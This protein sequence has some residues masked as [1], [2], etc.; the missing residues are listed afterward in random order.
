MAKFSVRR[1]AIDSF[2]EFADGTLPF[3][4]V[5]VVNEAEVKSFDAGQSFERGE[6]VFEYKTK[7]LVN[8][9][10][11]SR[12]GVVGVRF[13]IFTR[14]PRTNNLSSDDAIETFEVRFDTAQDVVFN[15]GGQNLFNAFNVTAPP[16]SLKKLLVANTS[17]MTLP[18]V[19]S[20]P[21]LSNILPGKTFKQISK[22][23]KSNNEDPAQVSAAGNFSA[24]TPFSAI[25]LGS[26]NNFFSHDNSI[27]SAA[28]ARAPRTRKSLASLRRTNRSA[29]RGKQ[30]RPLVRA[31]VS[32]SESRSRRSSVSFA[33]LLP[34]KREYV[35]T[36][37]L[38]KGEVQGSEKLYASISSIGAPRSRCIFTKTIVEI[39]H[40][41]EL[42]ELLANPE[43]PDV[44]LIDAKMASVSIVLKRTDPTL[45]VVR[46]FRI[47][48]NSNVG[49][50]YVDD[51]T[52]LSFSESPESNIVIFEDLLDN[53]LPNKTIYRFAVVN[54]DGSIGEFSSIVIPSFKNVSDPL[55]TA[56]IP[57][58]IRAINKNAGVDIRV[59][60]LSDDIFTIRLLRQ[61]FHKSG[62]FDESVEE[63][64]SIEGDLTVF[65]NGQKDAFYFRD[66]T[67]VLG[68]HYRYFVAYRTGT[69]GLASLGEEIISDE[70]ET[71]IR[72]F[73]TGEIPF[74]I[75]LT[76]PTALQDGDN[77]TTVTFE[78]FSEPTVDFFKT[79][80]TALRDAG[81]DTQFISNLSKDDLKPKFFTMFLVERINLNTGRRVSFGITP[82]GKFIDDSDK[83][84]KLG[85]PP[86]VSNGRYEYVVKTCLQQPEVFLQASTVGLINRY[87]DEIQ[88]LASRFAR[89]IYSRM[90]VLPPEFDVR[91]GRSIESL[92][93]ESQVGQELAV[94]VAIPK[95]EPIIE[96]MT[97]TE[98]SLYSSLTWRVSGDVSNVSYFLI[99]C[100][101]D[102][103]DQLLGAI[104]CSRGSALYRYRDDRFYGETGE[105]SYSVRAV[106]F[107]DD[108]VVKSPSIN[109][110]KL[111]SVPE[112]LLE[113]V[114]FSYGKGKNY[115]Q[116]IG[117]SINFQNPL[118]PPMTSPGVS[119]KVWSAQPSQLLEAKPKMPD[120][121]A[122]IFSWDRVDLPSFSG[123]GG[124]NKISQLESTSIEPSA[125][126]KKGLHSGKIDPTTV[127]V[128]DGKITS[129]IGIDKASLLS[130]WHSAANQLTIDWNMETFEAEVSN[131]ANKT[132]A[133]HLGM[134]EIKDM[135]FG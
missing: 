23:L 115:V 55:R 47:V 90:G 118:V 60:T 84:Q 35:Q 18:S 121:F 46:V 72:R 80:T 62:S 12:L 106:S 29:R 103:S 133:G 21:N 98:K 74:S 36:L 119:N 57:V 70:D 16:N 40:G 134:N 114:V 15:I 7:F 14:N 132:G 125:L 110:E 27:T 122:E 31:A 19:L 10:R 9:R 28:G 49:T 51:V 99:Y 53:V 50:R 92:M 54:G 11:A 124:D 37:Y 42:N 87:G 113:G 79:V 120:Q 89:A 108:V 107:D 123:K 75:S 3:D 82:A 5:D 73:V 48:T 69:I 22:D 63:I 135:L 131:S 65:V 64:L 26:S 117:Q 20:I 45:R 52:D 71:I 100:T 97:I 13:E 8:Q 17:M 126:I 129:A 58:A 101:Y 109:A 76:D 111:Y 81:V 77:N 66:E 96:D 1:V 43:P 116:P 86:P 130:A 41:R 104:A 24:V 44:S 94:R 4:L 56:S 85:L 38:G 68:R 93:L 105:K 102:G 59:N 78:I 88:R 83:R 112:N 6:G 61:E 39:N 32:R 128:S 67:A 95:T 25:S 34:V 33:E 2:F 91:E 127:K 30:D